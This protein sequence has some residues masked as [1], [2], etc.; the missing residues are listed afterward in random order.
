MHIGDVLVHRSEIPRSNPYIG[1]SLCGKERVEALR[2]FKYGG[3]TSQYTFWFA[4][5]CGGAR[6]ITDPVEVNWET[7]GL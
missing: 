1:E 5:S 7:S 6:Q 3:D 4:P 2:C